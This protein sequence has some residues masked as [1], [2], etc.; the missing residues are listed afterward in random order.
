MFR[1]NSSSTR[2][3]DPIASNWMGASPESIRHS[4]CSTAISSSCADRLIPGDHFAHLASPNSW[5]Y[6][7]EWFWY[8]GSR[9]ARFEVAK[10][11]FSFHRI[12]Q[13]MSVAREPLDLILRTPRAVHAMHMILRKRSMSA[14]ERSTVDAYLAREGAGYGPR[15]PALRM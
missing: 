7:T 15:L 10:L 8:L 4:A 2:S 6:S 1:A 5:L 13:E 12:G 3:S 9:E 11:W 14:E